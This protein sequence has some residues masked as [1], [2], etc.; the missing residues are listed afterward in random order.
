M[1]KKITKKVKT[2]TKVPQGYWITN[3]PTEQEYMDAVVKVINKYNGKYIKHFTT[4]KYQHDGDFI[5]IPYNSSNQY[6]VQSCDLIFSVTV[7]IEV[8]QELQQK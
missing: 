4:H 3:T 7:Y 1:I 8:P 5:Q 6:P 2:V